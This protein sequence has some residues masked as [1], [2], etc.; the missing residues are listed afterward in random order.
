MQHELATNL[1][2]NATGDTGTLDIEDSPAM[3][4]GE[5]N[6]VRIVAGVTFAAET[7][8]TTNGLDFIL[9][10]SNDLQKWFPIST[11][12]V[13]DGASEKPPHT[14]DGT[15]STSGYRYVRV[16]YVNKQTGKVEIFCNLNF[17]K[18]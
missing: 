13:A 15:D 9:Q 8:N 6:T 5:F 16:R 3:A 2:L 11:K 10:G 18:A 4:V 7:W 14:E 1:I 12:K 17:S